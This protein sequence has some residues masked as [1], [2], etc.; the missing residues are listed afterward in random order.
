MLDAAHFLP[1]LTTVRTDSAEIGTRSLRLLLD[2][3]RRPC[4]AAS[5]RLARPDRLARPGRPGVRRR[6]G[7][8]PEPAC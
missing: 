3:A 5:N 1:P 4:R 2:A 7:P 6:S 8:A